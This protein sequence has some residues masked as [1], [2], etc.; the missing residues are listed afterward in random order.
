M[1]PCSN[2]HVDLNHDL[3]TSKLLPHDWHLKPISPRPCC[4]IAFFPCSSALR[5]LLSPVLVLHSTSRHLMHE[6]VSWQRERD[7]WIK[8][9]WLPSCMTRSGYDHSGDVMLSRGDFGAI[10]HIDIHPPL[11]VTSI[12]AEKSQRRLVLSICVSTETLHVDI[13]PPLFVTSITAE[14]FS[15]RLRYYHAY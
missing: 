11:Y 2:L 13:N 8:F 14:T 15:R 5:S 7:N 9:R 12:T 4:K 10:M 1:L 3:D 6:D